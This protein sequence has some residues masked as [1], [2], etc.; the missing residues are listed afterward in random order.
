[1]IYSSC[2][3]WHDG[4]AYFAACC[5]DLGKNRETVDSLKLAAKYSPQ[6][7]KMLLGSLFPEGMPPK[8]YPNFFLNNMKNNNHGKTANN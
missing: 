7:L 8:D 4:Y 1:M 3:D 2:K 6:K 5:Y